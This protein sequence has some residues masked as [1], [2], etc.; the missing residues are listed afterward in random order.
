MLIYN[1]NLFH[2]QMF[3][4]HT[5]FYLWKLKK[6]P[7]SPICFIFG[8]SQTWNK[9]RKWN[10]RWWNN[11]RC[12]QYSKAG[13]LPVGKLALFRNRAEP[14]AWAKWAWR[15]AVPERSKHLAVA[16]GCQSKLALKSNIVG[17]NTQ[18]T[19]LHR[20]F[21]KVK[22]FEQLQMNIILSPECTGNSQSEIFFL[23]LFLICIFSDWEFRY[24][25]AAQP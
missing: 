11:W 7:P 16:S 6:K 12:W 1:A 8:G 15:W 4:F 18:P 21:A 23:M 10:N 24:S 17:R 19:H 25:K 5:Y 13:Y 14:W 20:W 22:R 3:L 2:L 9:W